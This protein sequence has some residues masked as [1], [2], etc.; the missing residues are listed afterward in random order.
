MTWEQFVAGRYL[1]GKLQ[2]GIIAAILAIVVFDVFAA[3]FFFGWLIYKRKRVSLITIISAIS[4]CGINIGVWALICVLGVFNGFNGI[5]KSL[6][7]GFD[8]HIRITAVEG[9]IQNADSLVR[10]VQAIPEVK[11]AGPFIN[12][13]SA[14]MIGN[15]LK[16]IEIR[17]MNAADA[18]SAIGLAKAM[19]SGS[20]PNGTP[21]LPHP[22]V[23]GRAL[24]FDL[25]I[26]KGDT[27]SLLSQS[28]LEE[29]LTQYAS[30]TII[31]AVVTGV[32]ESSNKE[33][34]TYRAYTDL[35]TAR[36]LFALP[37]GVMGIEVRVNDIEQ[38]EAVGKQLQTTLGSG[39]RVD[40]WQDLHRD[41]LAVME[42]ERWAAFVIL[43][44]IIIVAVFNV[45]GSLTM[46][47][48]E[49]GRDIGILKSMG[50]TDAAVRSIFLRQGLLIGLVGTIAGVI[51]GVLI[52][53]LQQEYGLIPLNNSVYIISALPVQMRVSDIAIISATALA[54]SGIAAIYPARRAAKLLP[55]DAV[56][57]E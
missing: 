14:L 36:Q 10:I 20:L 22:I 34:D 12:G 37:S 6:L 3:I 45:L 2:F 52:C 54:L 48:K 40:T 38:A 26:R 23:L 11:A 35:A 43:S 44:L 16:V 39:Y 25:R 15:E 7:V 33:Y 42:L 18:G 30:P 46:L 53:L 51:K 19:V 9:P 47:V 32:F 28:G 55:A 29:S 41:L 49:K 57:Y 56:R 24:S 31:R 21:Q 13:R 8:P 1:R 5:V 27:L 17:G 50:A 4:V